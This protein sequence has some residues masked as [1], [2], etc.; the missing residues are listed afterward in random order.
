MPAVSKKARKLA[1]SV[2]NA[3]DFPMESVSSEPSVDLRGNREARVYS[4]RSICRFSPE[5]VVI[6][7]S[8]CYIRFMGSHLVISDFVGCGVTVTGEINRVDLSEGEPC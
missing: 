3:L 5:E 2:A 6:K 7:C 1:V 8:S 4:W